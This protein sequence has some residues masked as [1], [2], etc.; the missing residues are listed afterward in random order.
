M[1]ALIELPD[2]TFRRVKAFAAARG[3]TLRRFFTNAVAQQLRRR[4]VAARDGAHPRD[5]ISG[6]SPVRLRNRRGWRDSA[7][8]PTSVTKTASS[9]I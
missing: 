6:T 1:K 3:I 7:A 5:T 9:S 8:F 2:I 4:A